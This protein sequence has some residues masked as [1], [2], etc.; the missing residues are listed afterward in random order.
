MRSL[1]DLSLELRTV[2][3]CLEHGVRVQAAHDLH[4]RTTTKYITSLRALYLL[5]YIIFEADLKQFLRVDEF[6]K[7]NDDEKTR[8]VE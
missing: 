5:L 2:L 1:D 3:R 8:D 4:Q 7:T 6:M